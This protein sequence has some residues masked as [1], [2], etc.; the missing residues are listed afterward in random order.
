MGGALWAA[1]GACLIIDKRDT[2]ATDLDAPIRAEWDSEM[3]SF[4]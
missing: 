4:R 2:I 1:H 3:V